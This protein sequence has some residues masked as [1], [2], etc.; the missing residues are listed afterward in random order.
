M[1]AAAQPRESTPLH[2]VA[3]VGAVVRDDGRVLA[4]KRADNGRWAP[5]GGVLELDESPEAGVRRE[6]WEETG[7]EVE[8]RQLTGV[9]KNM[10]RGVVALVFRCVPVGGTERTSDE[11]IAVSWLTLAEVAE[12][13]TEAHAVRFADALSEDA[14]HVRTHDGRRLITTA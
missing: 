13:M 5:P 6:V 1:N 7:V 12:A 10:T 3:V 14:P 2:S 11:S 4:I 9:Y 8:V